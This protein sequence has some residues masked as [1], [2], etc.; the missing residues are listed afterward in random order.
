MIQFVFLLYITIYKKH[1]VYVDIAV[2]YWETNVSS[3]T[4]ANIK[5]WEQGNKGETEKSD[6]R[7]GSFK[8]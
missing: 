8:D 3:Q 1:I 7:L 4:R 5:K 6:K 2:Y